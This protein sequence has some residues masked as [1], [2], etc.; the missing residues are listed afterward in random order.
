MDRKRHGSL[1]PWAEWPPSLVPPERPD[2]RPDLA[3]D[4]QARGGGRLPRPGG[5]GPRVR[6][7]P[8]CHCQ[9]PNPEQRRLGRRARTRRYCQDRCKRL[10]TP[11]ITSFGVAHSL[12]S[13]HVQFRQPHH[14]R[15]IEAA[16]C[17]LSGAPKTRKMRDSCRCR[18]LVPS[19][20]ICVTDRTRCQAS[21]PNQP[22]S[23]HDTGAPRSPQSNLLKATGGSSARSAT[24][25]TSSAAS[26]SAR[27]SGSSAL[28]S[29]TSAPVANRP[30]ATSSGTRHDPRR[31]LAASLRPLPL[32]A[33]HGPQA[34]PRHCYMA[35]RP[36]H[37]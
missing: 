28:A 24:T 21:S 27:R 12:G 31:V 13:S 1:P 30:T 19:L 7:V 20:C 22:P 33:L 9:T 4:L 18:F 29:P 34:R 8:A 6:A 36:R 16:N 37:N 23:L 14:H 15:S 3:R 26:A 25:A 11:A 10:W 5:K 2:N 17:K 32:P 35:H